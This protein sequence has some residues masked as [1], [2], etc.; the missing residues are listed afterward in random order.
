[1]L[2]YYKKHLPP[3]TPFLRSPSRVHSGPKTDFNVSNI[4]PGHRLLQL[5][6]VGQDFT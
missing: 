5:V 1:M 4:D 2:L 6:F 3:V